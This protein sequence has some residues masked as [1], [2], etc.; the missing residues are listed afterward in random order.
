MCLESV[1]ACS[2]RSPVITG[3]KWTATK[4]IHAK[5]FR[6]QEMVAARK[7]WVLSWGVR[8]GMKGKGGWY[9]GCVG[10]V[11]GFGLARYGLNCCDQL[12]CT[13]LKGPAVYQSAWL[14]PL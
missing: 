14:R 11:L 4:W 1:N 5:P 12:P 7:Q 3:V 9:S 2:V 13:Q 6:P 8:V 10:L